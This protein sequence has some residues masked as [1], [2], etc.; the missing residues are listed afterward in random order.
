MT[1]YLEEAKAYLEEHGWAH[2]PSVLSKQEAAHAQIGSGRPTSV[3]VFYLTELDQL[4]RN[5]IAHP[6]AVEMHGAALKPGPRLPGTLAGRLGAALNVVWCL[7]DV[8]EENGT[9]Q[10]IPGRNRWAYRGQVPANAPDL[11]VPFEGEAGDAIV[12]GGRVWYTSGS[13]VTEDEDCAL[14]FGYYTAPAMRQLANWTAKSPKDIQDSLSPEM[15][16]WL[17][18]NPGWKH[19]LDGGLEALERIVPGCEKKN[20]KQRADGNYLGARD[21]RAEDE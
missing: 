13:N 5:L 9:T 8:R 14:L 10:Y 1:V 4:F 19:R 12:M 15:R 7:T 17:G 11:L 6:T 21:N 16:E 20:R 3:R 2:I 18:L